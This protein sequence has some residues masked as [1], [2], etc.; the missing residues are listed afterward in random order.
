MPS[1]SLFGGAITL[2]A[3]LALLDASTL[4][5]VPDTQEVLLSHDSD[6]SIIVEVLQC[7]DKATD[8][9][10]M[11]VAA[12]Y[13]FDSLAHD[14][15]ALSSKVESVDAPCAAAAP[16]TTPKPA[17]LRGTQKVRKFGKATDEHEV[18]IYLAVYRLPAQN[19]DL[20]LSINDPEHTI[21]QA[22]AWRIA[23]SL[24]IRDWQLFP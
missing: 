18:V 22:A 2:E 6:V 15:D 23:H 20:V 7:V 17:L 5:Q 3:D 8:A 13:H 4:R 10:D 24:Q 21:S 16:Q 1:Y 14:N 11:G 19:V 9:A 12:R